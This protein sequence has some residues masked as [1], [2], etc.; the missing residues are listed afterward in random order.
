ML[1]FH[2]KLHF[3]LQVVIKGMCT[4]LLLSPQEYVYQEK[5][6]CMFP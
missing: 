3:L 2:L 4:K 1:P 6:C 5:M